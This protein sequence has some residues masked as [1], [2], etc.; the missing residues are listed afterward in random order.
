MIDTMDIDPARTAES[1]EQ[2]LHA[3]MQQRAAAAA[4]AS[5]SDDDDAET[6]AA[7]AEAA[8]ARATRRA[9]EAG[10]QRTAAAL[11]HQA[12]RAVEHGA[13]MQALQFYTEAIACLPHDVELLAARGSLC[14]R[15]DRAHA[16]L[17]DGELIVK[18]MPDW[19]KGHALCGLA[20]FCMKQ[21]GHAALAYRH[22]L[23]HAEGSPAAAGIS[24][25]LQDAQAKVGAVLRQAAI[26]GDVDGLAAQLKSGGADPELRD[27]AHGFTPLSLAAAAGRAECA[28][29]LVRAGADVDCRD[30]YGKTP[31]VW[32]AAG[33]HEATAQALLKVCAA[34][35]SHSI[36]THATLTRAP[37]LRGRA[38]LPC[39]PRIRADGTR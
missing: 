18:L 32:A 34:P 26:S 38:E 25:A 8:A 29:L 21:Y 35:R 6:A 5:C 33:G 27:E 4:E 19:Y 36:A 7:L 15:I 28:A 13:L 17:H 22:A 20:L 1:S 39:A 37:A 2:N 12:E 14:A 9:K 10:D 30:K 31:L 24:H 16:A 11:V 23:S 3:Y